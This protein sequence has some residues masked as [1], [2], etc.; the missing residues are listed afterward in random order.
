MNGIEINRR[1]EGEWIKSI[2]MYVRYG[3]V[4]PCDLRIKSKISPLTWVH[5]TRVIGNQFPSHY[6]AKQILN[7]CISHILTS[8][9]NLK[10]KLCSNQ[11]KC[12]MNYTLKMGHGINEK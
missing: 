9:P 5:S 8:T 1:N 2:K 6:C 11:G 3:L 7:Y 4:S 12:G 10:D